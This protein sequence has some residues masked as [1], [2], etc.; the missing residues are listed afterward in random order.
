MLT[1]FFL[2]KF[3]IQNFGKKKK[4]GPRGRPRKVLDVHSHQ[5][6]PKSKLICASAFLAARLFMYLHNSTQEI[7][8]P[9][10]LWSTWSYTQ[11]FK[12]DRGASWAY[13]AALSPKERKQIGH[14]LNDTHVASKTTDDSVP[15]HEWESKT[16]AWNWK[17]R[18]EDSVWCEAGEVWYNCKSNQTNSN[19]TKT[20]QTKPN[21]TKPKNSYSFCL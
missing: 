6:Q 1:F 17:S 14:A 11:A 10:S 13:I 9:I 18:G 15:W 3:S 16:R 8:V 7:Q 20:N 19:Q 5:W 2:T 4:F 21:R 12:Q